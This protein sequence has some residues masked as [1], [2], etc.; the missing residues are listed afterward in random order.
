MKL[1]R[2]MLIEAGLLVAVAVFG[3]LAVNHFVASE[4]Q[5]NQH[6]LKSELYDAAFELSVETLGAMNI[7]T[8]HYD[9]HA[10]KLGRFER[11]SNQLH[12][13]SD[14]QSGEVH[15]LVP[16]ITDFLNSVTGYMQL[17][18]TLRVSFR[19]ISQSPELEVGTP[20]V[21]EAELMR[22]VNLTSSYRNSA[23]PD[24]AAQIV[25][26][27]NWL[28]A[29][30]SGEA[31]NIYQWSMLTK[32]ARYIATEYGRALEL[33]EPIENTQV[34][35]DINSEITRL[36]FEIESNRNLAVLYGLAALVSVFLYLFTMLAR[37]TINLRVAS[38]ESLQ[39]A[40][41]KSQF[42]ANMSHELRTP[43]NGIVGLSNLLKRT[44]L[45]GRQV[46]YVSKL[47]YS[48]AS[49]N[50][51]VNDILDFSKLDNDAMD[52]E[53]IQFSMDEVFGYL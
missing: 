13:A 34:N 19:V 51:I 9:A 20:G 30:V 49:L 40:E 24:L 42:L 23:D 44:E 37:L 38:I 53:R 7:T 36:G 46:D 31:S 14:T 29:V 4:R 1:Q 27:A 35:E 45:D 33:L 12:Q 50:S 11:L 43:L 47:H 41:V 26:Q 15:P 17:A 21:M 22:L 16:S 2:N 32:H 28:D 6:E 18:S 52:L 39:A 8:S 25:N 5:K 48:A 3:I 10:E